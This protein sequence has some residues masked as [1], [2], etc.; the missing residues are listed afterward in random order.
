MVSMHD[1]NRL[2]FSY[3]QSFSSNIKVG[4]TAKQVFT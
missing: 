3:K 2:G 4:L 1:R